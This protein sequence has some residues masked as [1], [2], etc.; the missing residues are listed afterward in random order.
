[1][2]QF[3]EDGGHD[4]G[5]GRGLAETSTLVRRKK[6][7]GGKKGLQHQAQAQKMRHKLSRKDMT[8]AVSGSFPMTDR[9]SQSQMSQVTLQ[10]LTTTPDQISRKQSESPS[11]CLKRYFN[12][13]SGE[14]QTQQTATRQGKS[15]KLL[16][17]HMKTSSF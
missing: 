3:F 14:H 15:K 12:N 10:T 8:A 6:F 9:Y 7:E 2:K 16:R 17:G 1:M 5:N 13:K 4:N 11:S